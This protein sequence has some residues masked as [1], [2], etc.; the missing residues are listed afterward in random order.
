[1]NN[2]KKKNEKVIIK[3][4]SIKRNKIIITIFLVCLCIIGSL[5]APDILFGYIDSRN[6]NAVSEIKMSD[7][8]VLTEKE[9]TLSDKLQTL[10]NNPDIINAQVSREEERSVI[11]YARKELSLFLKSTKIE[12]LIE[13]DMFSEPHVLKKIYMP[14]E[15]QN[16]GFVAY[17][18]DFTINEYYRISVVIDK[19]DRTILQLTFE[20]SDILHYIDDYELYDFEYEF[21]SLLKSYYSDYEIAS[22]G[23][24]YND[25]SEKYEEDNYNIDEYDKQTLDNYD[26]EDAYDY[27]DSYYYDHLEL[28]YNFVLIDSDKN[29]VN[30]CVRI[31]GSTIIFNA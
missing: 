5:F 21:D 3:K 28:L 19:E 8:V 26:V 25:Y 23:I 17:T 1:M 12:K 13:G 31:L 9:I 30:Y 2:S 11:T 16:S 4:S 22:M 18:V 20:N 10:G 24:T 29:V 6:L 14:T 7:S 27:D 15:K